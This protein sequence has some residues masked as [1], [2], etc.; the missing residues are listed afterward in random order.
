MNSKIICIGREYGSGGREIGQKLAEA[1]GVTCYDKLL[2]KKAA[3]LSGMS[4]SFISSEDE[5]PLST[6]GLMSGNAFADSVSMGQAF[7]SGSQMAYAAEKKAIEDIASNG[8]CVIVGRCASSILRQSGA[9]SVFIYAGADDKVRRVM[10]RNDLGE[11]ESRMRIRR[12]DR[13]RRHYFD[14]YADTGWGERESYDL[15]LSSSALG[16]E[17]CVEAILAALSSG[18]AGEHE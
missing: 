10:Q 9:L 14:F 4:E 7:Y 6:A 1:L 17:G 11:K 13:L 18:K 8:S 12:V 15:M 16:M 3:Q 5:S 2:I